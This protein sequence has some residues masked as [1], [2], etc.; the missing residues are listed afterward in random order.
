MTSLDYFMKPALSKFG[1]HGAGGTLQGTYLCAI[2]I[3]A[4]SDNDIM[5]ISK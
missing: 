4:K 3:L 2:I 5:I 1:R